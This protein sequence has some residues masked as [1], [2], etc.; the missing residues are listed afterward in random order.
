MDFM[1]FIFGRSALKKAQA[2]AGAT[3][4][5]A[6]E[7]VTTPGVS[8]QDIAK[9]AQ[10]QADQ[11]RAKTFVGPIQPKTAKQVSGALMKP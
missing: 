6:P 5:T 2:P 8:Q 4:T 11:M 10:D 3:S 9:M 7:R 1:D